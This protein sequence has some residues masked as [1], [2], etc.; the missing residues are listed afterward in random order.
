MLPYRLET[1]AEIK[2]KEALVDRMWKGTLVVPESCVQSWRILI[3]QQFFISEFHCTRHKRHMW[4][5][6]GLAF[7][8][9][10]QGIHPASRGVA[11]HTASLFS[12][13]THTHTHIY[14]YIYIYYIHA[15]IYIY[16]CNYIYIYVYIYIGFVTMFP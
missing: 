16:I 2:D 5:L 10:P 11:A 4:A 13:V 14:I 7:S 15:H 3:A 8:Y 12:I 1:K 9:W 6:K